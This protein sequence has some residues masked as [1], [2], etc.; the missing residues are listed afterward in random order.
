MAIISLYT[1]GYLFPFD[2]SQELTPPVQILDQVLGSA[3]RRGVVLDP[4]LANSRCAVQFAIVAQTGISATEYL[5]P[6]F[7]TVLLEM[8]GLPP[9]A[10]HRPASSRRGAVVC[11]TSGTFAGQRI[12]EKEFQRGP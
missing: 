11:I 9:T 7:E 4:L 1:R 8:A 10:L 3:D 2:V 12:L 6:A 5:R